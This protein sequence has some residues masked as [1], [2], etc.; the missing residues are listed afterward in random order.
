MPTSAGTAADRVRARPCRRRAS[1]RVAGGARLLGIDGSCGRSSHAHG[2]R[3]DHDRVDARAQRVEELV[4]RAVGHR[5]RAPRDRR[6]PR[7]RRDPVRRATNG[8]SR[9]RLACTAAARS[10]AVSPFG[11]VGKRRAKRSIR[12]RARARSASRG[13]T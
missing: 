7:P 8:R 13:G 11:P 12:P 2:L 5:R 6:A 1:P 3:P 10:V 4:V 9:R